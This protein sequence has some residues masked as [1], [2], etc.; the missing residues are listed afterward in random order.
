MCCSLQSTMLFTVVWTLGATGDKASWEKF[1][2]FF[3]E[4]TGG[5]IPDNIGK[6]ECPM[7]PEGTVYDYLFEP[8]GRGKWTLWLDT[9]KNTG[10]DPSIKKL[11]DII[12]PTMDTVR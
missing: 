7:P 3:R 6:I 11:S 2:A 12:V 8:K 10:I 5:P 1:D 4:L 9:I